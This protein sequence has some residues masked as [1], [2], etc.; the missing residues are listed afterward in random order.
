QRGWW[1]GAGGLEWAAPTEEH[2]YLEN[3]PWDLAV[4]R[5]AAAVTVTASTTERQTGLALAGSVTLRADEA[6]F[7]VRLAAQNP[8]GAPR[9]LQMWTNA[10]LSP[11]GD[12]RAGPGL[13]FVVPSDR[14][15]VHATADR[16]LPGPRAW[17]AWPRDGGRDLS[18]PATW[19]GYLGAFTPAPVPFL[20]AYDEIA[21]SGAAVVHGPGAV[22]GKVFGFS[23][24]VDR[25]LYT[26]GDSEY[27]EL[28]SGAQPTFWDYPPLEAGATRA[29][30]T[31]WLP[32][33]GLGRLAV[34]APDGALGLLRRD[35][36]GLTVSLATPRVIPAA[37]V[38]VTL[39]GREAF[40]SAPLTLRPDQP[41]AIELP[42]GAGGRV[43]VEAAGL[44][45]EA[46]GE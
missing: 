15:I 7:A 36:G 19:T 20:G 32:L 34:A 1:L 40:R 37:T 35:D 4:S 2:G 17:I 14:M 44:S 46:P 42:P 10:T 22:G 13:R 6:R 43:R 25:G 9:P 31:S 30:E 12:N 29:I 18:V 24:A 5:G 39:D 11:A 28:W 41:L 27:V 8:T 26:D 33:W 38:V 21:D 16:A 45:L 3:L 23:P